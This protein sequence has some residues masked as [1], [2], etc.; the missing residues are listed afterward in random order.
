MEPE[1][2]TALTDTPG[3]SSVATVATHTNRVGLV[4]ASSQVT[5]ARS[6]GGHS[7]AEAWTLLTE[8]YTRL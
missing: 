2:R 3:I 6:Q 7:A 5:S 4:D 1:R 8:G